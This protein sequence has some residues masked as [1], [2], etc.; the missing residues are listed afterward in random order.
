MIESDWELISQEMAIDNPDEDELE[1]LDDECAEAAGLFLGKWTEASDKKAVILKETCPLSTFVVSICVGPFA[2]RERRIPGFPVMKIYAR[3]S[4][5]EKVNCEEMFDVVESGIAFYRDFLGQE[6][7]LSHYC[8]VFVPEHNF[9][10]M[11]NVG[12][13]TTGVIEGNEAEYVHTNSPP[14]SP[15]TFNESYIW[16]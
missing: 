7:P 1:E 2:S 5:I 13:V 10:A 8:Q 16:E 14:S 6:F 12:C 15:I 11:E 9:F 3:P 4:M